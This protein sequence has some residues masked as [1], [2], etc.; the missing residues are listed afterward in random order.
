MVF[1]SL[2]AMLCNHGFFIRWFHTIYCALMSSWKTFWYGYWWN[3][4]KYLR[5]FK[6]PILCG[7]LDIFASAGLCYIAL[8]FLWCI[9][10]SY[11]WIILEIDAYVLTWITIWKSELYAPHSMTDDIFLLH[12]DVYHKLSLHI[13]NFIYSCYEKLIYC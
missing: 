4:M 1:I 9:E 13:R 12:L 2:Q 11:I 5:E 7:I 6:P 10:R 3:L 8:Y